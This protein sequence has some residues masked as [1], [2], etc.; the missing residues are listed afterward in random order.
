[1][2]I[3]F[4]CD[5]WDPARGSLVRQIHERARALRARGHATKLFAT[6]QDGGAEDEIEHAGLAIR[7]VPSRYPLRFRPLVGLWNPSV[8][9]ALDQELAR[10]RPE[11][12]HAELVH[13]HIS[14][15][16]LRVAAA[17]GARV[18]F[19]AHD[20]M[21][22]CYQKMDCFHG[23]EAA[24]GLGTDLRARLTKCLPCQGL[25]FLP[26]RNTAIR[27][28]L[29]AA[30]AV[31][32]VSEALAARLRDHG[33]RCDAVLPNALLAPPPPP[34][35]SQLAAA[36]ARF[37]IDGAP[38]VLFAGRIQAQK[39]ILALLE[40]LAVLASRG[41]SFR[42]LVAGAHEEWSAH[43][44]PRAL[45][46]GLAERTRVTGWLGVEQLEEA[47]ALA[48]VLCV[49]ST[50]FETFGLVHLEAMARGVPAIGTL[51]GGVPETIGAGGEVVNPFDIP[52][53]ARALEEL[54]YDDARHARAS[55]A[56]RARARA[57]DAEALLGRW[58]ALYAAR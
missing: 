1:M 4:L 25:R 55:A 15:R 52:A 23:G 32:A 54:L 43:A 36:R 26:G 6:R 47:Y 37:G 42:L 13:T 10:F 49:P 9:R 22:F 2:R 31:T 51:Y 19:S 50:C 21:T 12:V 58:L 16:A 5:L 45:A 11:V 24:G 40:A 41:R 48:R 7:R 53:L 18:V 28:A 8:V 3:L 56:A 27:R 46:L 35:A 14:Y 38:I 33:L 17:H 44:A 30:H 39:G 34:S 20:A 57:F 29:R